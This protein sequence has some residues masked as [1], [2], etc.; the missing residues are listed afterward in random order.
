MYKPKIYYVRVK[1]KNGLYYVVARTRTCFV[2][3]NAV[4]DRTMYRPCLSRTYSRRH[5]TPVYR[6][7]DVQCT[8]E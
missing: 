2:V 7:K 8:N 4:V 1:Y 5:C 3:R 6:P